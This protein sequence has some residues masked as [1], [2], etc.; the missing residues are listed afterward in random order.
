M[1]I[2]DSLFNVIKSMKQQIVWAN[3]IILNIA[4]LM[5]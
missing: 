5:L 3:V 1:T 2:Q 4:L